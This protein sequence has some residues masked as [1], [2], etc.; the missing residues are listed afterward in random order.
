[1]NT[2]CVSTIRELLY[3][4]IRE[5][6]R[7][8]GRGM[9]NNPANLRAFGIRD[10]ERR[11]C[12]LERFFTPVLQ[13]LYHRGLI[14]GAFRDSALVGVCGMARP[15]LCQPKAL[16][17]LRVVPSV[18]LGNPIGTPLRVLRWAAEWAHRDPVEPH[19]HLGPVTVDS[20]HQ[21]H[22]IGGAMLTAFCV[23]VDLCQ[24]LSYLETDKSENI[25]FYR[26]F[27]FTV[28][29]EAEVLGVPNWFMSRSPGITSTSFPLQSRITGLRP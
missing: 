7:V 13:G 8:L 19:W 12:T 4:E 6:A 21:G 24:T 28:V 9:C 26:K 27:G 14:F 3:T 17:K 23:L 5:A 25:R 22:G 1:M 18:A 29:A 2:I 11:C 20:N 16:E 15:G 10:T